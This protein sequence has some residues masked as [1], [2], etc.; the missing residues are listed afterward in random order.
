MRPMARLLGSMLLWGLA[1]LAGC[2]TAPAPSL[3]SAALLESFHLVGRVSVRQGEEGFSGSLDWWHRPAGDELD[4][5]GPLGQ[6]VARLYRDPEA[7]TLVTADG[8]IQ[9]AADAESLTERALGW[10]LP[11][12][13]LARWVQ[14]QPALGPVDALRQDETGR[15]AELVQDG[16]RIEYGAWRATPGGAL[17]GRIS[18]QGHGLSLKLVVDAWGP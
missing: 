15:I 10:R 11:L 3:P 14:A 5:L 17:P 8:V 13:R 4:I 9:R 1:L 2:A 16:W 18:V 7:I 6:G 12:S